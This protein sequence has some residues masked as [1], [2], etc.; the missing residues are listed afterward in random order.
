MIIQS[1]QDW[2]PL[3]ALALVCLCPA[4]PTPCSCLDC[5]CQAGAS[6]GQ[7]AQRSHRTVTPDPGLVSPESFM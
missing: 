5:L 6:P 3:S 2:K 7:L 4:G 1:K